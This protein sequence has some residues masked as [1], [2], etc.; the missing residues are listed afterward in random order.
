ME[1]KQE[2]TYGK[3][4]YRRVLTLFGRSVL[5]SFLG[6][7]FV[8]IIG[9]ALNSTF[10]K[11]VAQSISIIM[12]VG[13]IYATAWNEGDKD[14]NLVGFGRIKEDKLKGVKLGAIVMIPYMLSGVLLVLGLLGITTDLQ[15][16][17]RIIHFQILVILNELM[18]A[19]KSSWN[20]L[21]FGTLYYLSVPIASGVGYYLGYKRIAVLNKI[22]YGKQPTGADKK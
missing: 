1:K 4:F 12:F 20:G 17:Y 22:M 2:I 5:G 14:K 15:A 21:I 10:L 18:E 16:I 11:V 9:M 8:V 19:A 3:P 13:I 7:I 6:A